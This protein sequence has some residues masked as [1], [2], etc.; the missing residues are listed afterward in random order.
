MSFITQFFFQELAELAL[1]TYKHIGRIRCARLVGREVASFYMLLG[2]TQKAAAFLS[3]ALRTFENDKW[4][5]LIAQTHLE[6]AECYKKAKDIRKL[7][8]SSASVSAALEIDTLIR[9]TY[10]DEMRKSLECLTEPLVVPFSDIIKI[11]SVCV[12]NDGAVMQDNDIKV[13]LVVESNFPREIMCTNIMISLEIDSKDNKKTNAKFCASRVLTAKDMKQ[14]DPMMQKLKMNKT[15]NYRQ[16][17]QLEL[18]SIAAKF[19]DGKRKECS[20]NQNLGDFSNYLEVNNVV[21]IYYIL[22]Y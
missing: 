17:K 14:P 2:E 6:L 21:S 9:W 8:S 16:D 19:V 15:L 4:H 1:G 12:K 20:S 5:D 22:N 10:F 3:D 7:I 18:A 13:E 11:L